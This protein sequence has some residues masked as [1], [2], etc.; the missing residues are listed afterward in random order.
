MHLQYIHNHRHAYVRCELWGAMHFIVHLCFFH[1]SFISWC[2]HQVL[3]IPLSEKLCR[4]TTHGLK[5]AQEYVYFSMFNFSMNTNICGERC[6]STFYP[7]LHKF[8]VRSNLYKWDPWC[9][10]CRKGKPM[11]TENVI[12]CYTAWDLWM[13][14]LENLDIFTDKKAALIFNYNFGFL[15]L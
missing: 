8:F 2:H 9:C 10:S 7:S 12:L 13:P 5:D 3:L 6:T 1:L 15:R 11:Q 14:P 4:S